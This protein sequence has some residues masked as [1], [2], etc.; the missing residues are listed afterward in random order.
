MKKSRIFTMALAT[1]LCF[2]LIG[3][4]GKTSASDK[5]K[6]N[7]TPVEEKKV[8]GGEF[9][10]PMPG[11][12]PNLNPLIST[13]KE[14]VIMMN[15]IYDPLFMSNSNGTR[16]YLAEKYEISKDNLSVTIKLRDNIKWHDGV[17]ITSDDV[18]FTVESILD[19]S[20][21]IRFTNT[22]KVNGEPIKA[23]KVDD[24]TVRFELPSVSA[25]F[26]TLIGKLN[27]IPRHIYEGESDIAKSEKSNI[28]IGSGPYKVKE[29]RRG[30]S[31]SLE[32]YEDYHMGKPSIEKVIFKIV[33]DQS[34]QEM[35]L[36]NKELSM[37]EIND[38]T[39]HDKYEKDNNYNVYSYE[40]GRV[41]YMAFNYNSELMKNP[42]AR[43]A[44]ASALN[45]D[46]IVKGA[47]GSKR[48]AMAANSCFAPT[49]YFYDEKIENYKQDLE[50]SK[51]LIEE[52]GLSGKTIKLIYNSNRGN[53]ENTALIIQQQLKDVGINVEVIQYETQSF[54]DKFRSHQDDY[55]L[56][57]NGFPS[58]DEPDSFKAMFIT[59]GASSKNVYSSPEAD[60]LW[61]AG[62]I[63][64]DKVK[65]EEIYK[66]LQKQIKDDFTIF[67]IAYPNFSMATQ[68][69]FK[70]LDEIKAIPIFEDYTKLYMV[71]K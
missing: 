25:P 32:R 2:S 34:A 51:K 38:D 22:V 19:E 43:E 31:L 21:G 39:K 27:I 17:S 20:K 6:G 37:R 68:S 45:V 36:Q 70:G 46:D 35:G 18:I 44:I 53:Q 66:K 42:K 65:R 62:V 1:I 4:G 48:V 29:W 64:M 41:N 14:G 69:K 57:L 67:P 71:G 28:G 33:P 50:K 23:V 5:S 56:G 10:I 49:A 13:S 52:S 16:Y 63:E 3:C 59:G 58:P 60:T 15:P 8:D 47:Y 12:V 30:E 54:F 40:E 55:E 11:D 24:R 61:K 7:T 26:I 9:I